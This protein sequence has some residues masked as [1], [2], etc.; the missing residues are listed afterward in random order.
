MQLDDV[1]A[2]TTPDP[3]RVEDAMLRSIRYVLPG[4][5]G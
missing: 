3:Q 5:G 2:S 1:I 4:E